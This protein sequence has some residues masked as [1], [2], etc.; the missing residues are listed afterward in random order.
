MLR[1]APL[2]V[3]Y[4]PLGR[5]NRPPTAAHSAHF[6]PGTRH[7]LTPHVPGTAV[8]IHARRVFRRG[9]GD[10]PTPG[11]TSPAGQQ[12]VLA[13]GQRPGSP[14]SVAV[15][16]PRRPAPSGCTPP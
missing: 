3:R 13:P 6:P 9:G 1:P 11:T 5:T 15:D 4:G 7:P 12:S 8:D 16:P 2:P 14:R 10:T